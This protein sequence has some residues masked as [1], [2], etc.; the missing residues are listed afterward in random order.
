MVMTAALRFN[1]KPKIGLSFLEESKLIYAD[2]SV[3][4]DRPKSL[5]RFLK[6]C[7]RL[8]KRVLGDFIS[9]PEQIEVLRAFISLFDFKGVSILQQ[10]RSLVLTQVASISEAYS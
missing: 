4:A 1:A 7:G 3:P 9:R 5:A 2:V 6:N 10:P 8:D